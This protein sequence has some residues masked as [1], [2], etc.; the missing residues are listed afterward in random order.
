ML[1]VVL[2]SN[3]I[4]GDP[5][6][7]S[8]VGVVL[9]GLAEREACIIVV[10]EVVRDELY[11]QRREAAE[12]SHAQASKAIRAMARAGVDVVQTAAHLEASFDRIRSD[13]DAAFANLFSRV[14]VELRP[15]PNTAVSDVIKRDLSRRRPFQEITHH[16]KTKSLGFRDVVIWETVIEVL[17]PAHGNEKVLFVTADKGFLAGDSSSLHQDLLDDLDRHGIDRTR[18]VTVKNVLN[19]N[20]EIQTNAAQAAKVTAATNALYELVGEEVGEQLAYGGDYER[21]DFVR[22]QVP[23]IESAYISDIEQTSEFAF[24]SDGSVV[25][26]TA[27][28]TITVE[29]AIFKGDWFIDS[30][31]SVEIVGELN[32]HYFDAF[33]TVPVRVVLKMT[34]EGDLPEVVSIVL[35]DGDAEAA[36]EASH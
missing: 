11:R 24:E 36:I 20:A 8:E 32:N 6:L 7:T 14:G 26:A 25:T 10:P 30:G 19:V 29:G 4:H 18:I 9:V 33:S 34:L 1:T 27:D 31:D 28:A 5:W 21:P 23:G 17:D 13:L 16:Q 3:A 15:T 2:D 22:F 35:E 12:E